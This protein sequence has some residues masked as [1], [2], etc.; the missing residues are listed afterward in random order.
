[1]Y[2]VDSLV[3]VE[4]GQFV[5]DPAVMYPATIARILS[6]DPYSVP[7]EFGSPEKGRS[8]QDKVKEFPA[9]AWESALTPRDDVASENVALRASALAEARCWF[10]AALVAK[11]EGE[12]IKIHYL[13]NPDWR[14]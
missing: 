2:N 13:K 8:M 3:T 5:V 11:H 10:Q 6:L 7:Q 1:M 14:E 9:F 12:A 4:N